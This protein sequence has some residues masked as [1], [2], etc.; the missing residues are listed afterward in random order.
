MVYVTDA[1]TEQCYV[2]YLYWKHLMLLSCVMLGN[3]YSRKKGMNKGWGRRNFSVVK[4]K[5]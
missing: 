2:M 4:K 1:R 3:V 5:H